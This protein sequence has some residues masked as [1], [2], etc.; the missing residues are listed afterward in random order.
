MLNT[1]PYNKMMKESLHSAEALNILRN[2][3][4]ECSVIAKNFEEGTSKYSVIN[5]KINKLISAYERISDS[6]QPVSCRELIGL[7]E[8]MSGHARRMADKMYRYSGMEKASI[9]TDYSEG[10]DAH[11]YSSMGLET[12]GIIANIEPDAIYIRTP[13]LYS[14]SRNTRDPFLSHSIQAYADEVSKAIELSP[15]YGS[16][17][18]NLYA[19]KT[20]FYLYVLDDLSPHIDNDNYDTTAITN[21]I[22]R[23]LYGGDSPLTCR[24]VYDSVRSDMLKS[25]TYITVLPGRNPLP[26]NNLIIQ[27]WCSVIKE[28]R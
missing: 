20:L 7:L 28:K 22:V 4:D 2:M 19:N 17:D 27:Y 13:L 24:M 8:Q 3:R 11:L 26:D 1:A 5:S 10:L 21:G 25:G 16:L 15:A 9:L 14:R 6:N 23:H 12:K 18:R